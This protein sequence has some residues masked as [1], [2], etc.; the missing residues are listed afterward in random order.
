MI[1][2]LFI[3]IY[4]YYYC[5][6]NQCPHQ[7]VWK[8]A[9]VPLLPPWMVSKLK[10]PLKL[11]TCPLALRPTEKRQLLGVKTAMTMTITKANKTIWRTGF[12]LTLSNIFYNN[13][14]IFYFF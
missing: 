3:I 4:M 1:K 2:K 8:R 11:P 7:S 5:E 14:E 12:F 6:K 10:P 13:N 9:R